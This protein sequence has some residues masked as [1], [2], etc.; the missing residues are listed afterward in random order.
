MKYKEIVDQ[1]YTKE[2]KNTGLSKLST[3]R[4][5]F[6]RN[7]ETESILKIL[8]KHKNNKVSIL[9]AGCGNGYTLSLVSKKFKNFKLTGFEKNK[10]LFRLSIK[11]KSRKITFYN[12]DILSLNKDFIKKFNIIIVQRVLINLLNKKD[13][14]KALKNLR[15]YL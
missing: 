3:M 9:D 6:I 12:M 13:E 5:L 14:I 15:K 7:L 1:H 10:E 2:A 11:R 8:D 4:D